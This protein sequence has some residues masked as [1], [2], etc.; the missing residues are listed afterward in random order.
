MKKRNRPTVKRWLAALLAVVLLLSVC[1][2]TVL[3]ADIVESGVCGEN[4]TWTL[5]SEGLLTISGAG[6]MYDYDI[7]WSSAADDYITTA[8]W[9]GKE[10]PAV[11][12]GNS[13]TSIGY[14]AFYGCTG[15]T[16]VTIGNS[17]TSIGR[18]AFGGCDR[19][20]SLT[21]AA[22]NSVYHSAENCIIETASKTLVVGCK[23]SVIPTDGS[24][25]GIG[26]QELTDPFEAE[27]K[28]AE[29][30]GRPLPS[31]APKE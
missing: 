11:V 2:P 5:D 7:T 15:L 29:E 10:V 24:V 14:A 21:V 25:T 9:G 26:Y 17:V 30:Q 1:P 23:N 4:L 8:P 3:G 27:R 20:E 6:E 12:I 28:E 31:P 16:D 18:S 22:N 19:L 13:V